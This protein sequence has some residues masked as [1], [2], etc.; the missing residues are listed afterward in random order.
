QPGSHDSSI[1]NIVSQPFLD[2][3]AG[4]GRAKAGDLIV[5]VGGP[6]SLTSKVL[7][8]LRQHLGDK[9]G[10]I[11]KNRL[12]FLWVTDFPL[13]ERDPASGA[14]S[15]A[16]HPFT[17]PLPEDVDKLDSAPAEVRSRAYDVVLNG[18][19]I[20]GGS[21]RIHRQDVQRKV[22]R[23]LGISDEDAEYKFG[24]LLNAFRF[25]PPPH[26]GIAMGVDRIAMLLTGTDSIRDVIAFPKTARASALMEDAPSKVDERE[27]L[28]LHIRKITGK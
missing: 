12:D 9:E 25:G 27:L 2:K 13:F 10:L 26:G 18:N 1:K 6:D 22:F 21:I 16:H 14:I 8:R 24:F 28:E 23:A 3:A 15:P 20:G 7:A 19:E 17:S 5:L 11:D 4:L